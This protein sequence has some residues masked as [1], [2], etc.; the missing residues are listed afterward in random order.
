MTSPLGLAAS[1]SVHPCGAGTANG[2]ASMMVGAVEAH[3]PA[4]DTSTIDPR[5][6]RPQCISVFSL[7][8][9]TGGKRARMRDEHRF[10]EKIQLSLE[11]RHVR[12]IEFAAVLFLRAA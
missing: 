9:A 5:R 11:S 2:P 7:R 1:R 6:W 3:A 10:R 12:A 4:S 8:R